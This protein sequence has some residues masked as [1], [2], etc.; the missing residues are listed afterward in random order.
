MNKPN[1]DL[2]KKE[3]IKYFEKRNEILF[4][5]IFGSQITKKTN[6]FS[7]IDIAI[8]TNPELID[9]NDYRYGYKAA[10]LSDL[11][12]I[13]KT[14]KIDLVILNQATPLLRHRV[15]YFGELIYTD[16]EKKRISFQVDTINKYVDYKMLQR[17]IS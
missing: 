15:I 9:E 3:L 11:M 4:V 2:L 14:N 12:Q 6:K 10:I 17:K 8:Y 13:L 5:Y 16:D 1:L 7:D